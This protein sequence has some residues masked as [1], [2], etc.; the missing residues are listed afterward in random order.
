MCKQVKEQAPA[1]EARPPPPTSTFL[2]QAVAEEARPLQITQ[3][4]ADPHV[5]PAERVD[6]IVL[7]GHLLTLQL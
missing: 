1:S 5:H 7:H 2:E 4:P 3:L 6:V